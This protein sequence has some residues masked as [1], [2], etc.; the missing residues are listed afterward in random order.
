MLAFTFA[1]A[2][3]NVGYAD[4]DADAASAGGGDVAFAAFFTSAWDAKKAF[5]CS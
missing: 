1:D 5:I 4:V 2:A 3:W